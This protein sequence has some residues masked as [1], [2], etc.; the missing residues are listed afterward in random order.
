MKY[1][2]KDEL[3]NL[4]EE[5]HV[6][7][8]FM[9]ILKEEVDDFF[10][11]FNDS[12]DKIS[13]WGHHY[14]CKEDGGL[15]IY[16]D[17]TPNEHICSICGKKYSNDLLN[18]VWVC[19]YRNQGVVNTWK[20][21]LVYKYTG[22]RKYLDNVITFTDFYSDNY[23]KFK[24][25]NKEGNEYESLEEMAWGCS[26]I[27]PQSLNESI[28]II[29]LINALEIVKE[30]LSSDYITKIEKSFFAEAFKMFKPQVDKIH[31]I[32][33]WLNSSIGVMGLFLD[34]KEMIDFTFK[35][36]FNINEQLLKGVTKD[37]FWYEGSIHY[38]FF[39][40]EGIINLLLFSKLYGYDF[41]IGEETVEKM[42]INAY[43]YAFDNHQ[44]PN[45]NDGWPNINLK[46]YSYI[47]AIGGKIYSYDSEVG[48]ILINILKKEG[49]RHGFPLSK[50]YYYKNDISLEE[51]IFTPN[52]RYQNDKVITCDSINFDTSY[53]GIIKKNDINIFYK[54]GHNG[55]SHAH[56][57][58]MNIEVVIKGISLSRDLSNSGYGNVLCNEW[59]RV[60]ASHNTV[61]VNGNNHTSVSGGN[62]LS[63]TDSSF[64]VKA[65]DVYDDVDFVR[66]VSITNNGFKDQFKIEMEKEGICDYF[67][68]VEGDI[69]CEL[70]YCDAN[71]IFKGNGYQH[72]KDV[73]KVVTDAKMIEICWDLKGLGVV[74]SIDLNNKELFI[75]KSPDNPVTNYR[76]TIIIREKG[77]NPVYNLEW[78][79]KG[80]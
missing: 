46:S 4:I 27:M 54:Y 50:P 15:L 41:K 19:M 69:A 58:K 78:S 53:C 73:K 13:R 3:S 52:A 16:N 1:L 14:F 11:N 63:V 32:S 18:G 62:R 24:L 22:D 68:H 66:G 57:D 42:L 55:P 33:C 45:P 31:N 60:S 6:Y 37:G 43:H 40:I 28:F 38:N 39:T 29:R 26:R 80:E 72:L 65:E 49:E 75:A 34:N 56:P 2:M 20:S 61:V 7:K 70:D 76:T 23:L 47:Y 67:F 25:H 59:H 74:S 48:R 44:L 9:D 17:K 51:F 21:A 36:D 30:D 10:S 8:D 77:I 64:E 5:K 12:P 35:G 71:L 79:I